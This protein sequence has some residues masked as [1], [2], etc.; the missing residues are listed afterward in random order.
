MMIAVYT[1]PVMTIPQVW[2]IY[3]ENQVE[4]VS[5]ISWLSYALISV[6]W[7][8]HGLKQKDTNLIVNNLMYAILC[9]AITIGVF[10]K[11]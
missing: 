1:G 11:R 6:I 4:G 5:W 9:T 7:I 8:R 2:K 10:I 3:V